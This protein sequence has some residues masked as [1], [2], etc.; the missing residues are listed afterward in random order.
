M[1]SLIGMLQLLG[2]HVTGSDKDAYPPMS[3]MLLTLWEWLYMSASII[4]LKN[5]NLS[6][7]PFPAS[8][9]LSEPLRRLVPKYAT[10]TRLIYAVS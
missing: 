9:F 3:P 5:D 4:D 2:H 7:T 10:T 8:R 1:A 6:S